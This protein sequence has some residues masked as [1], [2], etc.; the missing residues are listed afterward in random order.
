MD[1]RLGEPAR[2]VVSVTVAAPDGMSADAL[3]T[4]L[5]VLGPDEGEAFLRRESLDDEVTAVWILDGPPAGDLPGDLPGDVIV[6]R[7]AGVTVELE[8][9]GL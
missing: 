4:L 5:F 2:G 3:S 6:H 1:P 8:P 9:P 7:G